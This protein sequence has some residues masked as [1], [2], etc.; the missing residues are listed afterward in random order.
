MCGRFI[1]VWP[2]IPP[3][4]RDLAELFNSTA[5]AFLVQVDYF[6]VARHTGE[7]AF[8]IRPRIHSYGLKEKI[9][10]FLAH[11]FFVHFQPAIQLPWNPYGTRRG[12]CTRATGL[13]W[14][15]DASMITR[16]LP[17]RTGS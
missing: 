15:S 13:P 5:W 17:S 16:S 2:A 4:G 1:N 7:M 10:R 9:S 6:R 8:C 3:C 12:S 11:P 14:K